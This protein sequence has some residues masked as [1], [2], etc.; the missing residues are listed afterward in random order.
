MKAVF[1]GETEIFAFP[2]APAMSE[3]DESSENSLKNNRKK[4]K[5]EDIDIS[6][7]YDFGIDE[8]E[9]TNYNEDI[10][11]LLLILDSEN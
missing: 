9:F 11:E 4:I 7:I 2:F 8:S 10:P 5:I 1:W 3:D 6:R